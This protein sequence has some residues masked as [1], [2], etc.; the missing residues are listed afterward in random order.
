MTGDA[1]FCQRPLARLIVEARRDY[2]FAVKNNRPDLH[3]AVPTAFADATPATADAGR[4]KKGGAVVTRR[5]WLDV[6]TAD[7]A[8]G[9]V[10]LPGP[11]NPAA[12]R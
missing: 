2:L 5:L 6:E 7:Y 3:E 9:G 11:A 8:Q 10:V 4:A 12:G 1:L